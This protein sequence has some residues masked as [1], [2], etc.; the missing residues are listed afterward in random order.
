M[1][2][3]STN[4]HPY[5]YRVLKQVHPE[6]GLSGTA[7]SSINN[8]VKIIIEKIMSGVNQLILRTG[9]KT[10]S[11]RD[12]QSAT[13]LILSGELAKH[14]VVEGTKSVVRYTSSKASRKEMKDRESIEKMSP[15]SRSSMAGLKFP[16]TR[17]QNIMVE[18]STS[19]RKTETSA[20][21]LASVCEYL[22][23]EVLELAGNAAKDSKRVRITPR[24]V[25]M[26]VRNDEEL[27][28]LFKDTVFA[29]GVIPHIDSSILPVK[30][31]SSK[32]KQTSKKVKSENSSKQTPKKNK[33]ES[34][35]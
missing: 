27:D 31:S 9:K 21:Y 35:K 6:T 11:S 8:M 33:V 28:R 18:I 12:I 22:I 19:S 1:T 23:A 15:V 7:L 29:G 17:V 2:L 26:A 13:R 10:I 30:K 20:V 3:D 24:H 14:A 5:I 25:M 4:F 16:I 32:P 34:K